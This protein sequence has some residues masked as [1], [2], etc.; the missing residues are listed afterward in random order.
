MDAGLVVELD[1]PHILLQDPDGFLS[2]MVERTG[3]AMADH[4]K[5]VAHEVLLINSITIAVY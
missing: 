4:L 1:H 5:K 3:T 2:R